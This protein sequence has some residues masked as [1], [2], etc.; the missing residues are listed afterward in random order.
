MRSAPALHV[1]GVNALVDQ[2]RGP[3][4]AHPDRMAPEIEQHILALSQELF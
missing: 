2:R 4:I 3:T 1:G